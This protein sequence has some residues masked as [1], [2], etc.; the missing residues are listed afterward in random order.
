MLL[1]TVLLNNASFFR[2][3]FSKQK[4]VKRAGYLRWENSNP[5]NLLSNSLTV[6]PSLTAADD[7]W[8]KASLTEAQLCFLSTKKDIN[9]TGWNYKWNDC[10]CTFHAVLVGLRSLQMVH[11]PLPNAW[12]GNQRKSPK[13]HRLPNFIND[14]NFK[15]FSITQL[16]HIVCDCA[17]FQNRGLLVNKPLVRILVFIHR[18]N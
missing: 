4:D 7:H 13:F 9:T 16:H 11:F 15:R 10:V 2:G 1:L 18:M 5:W 6:T 14:E 8:T 17:L 12:N 3:K